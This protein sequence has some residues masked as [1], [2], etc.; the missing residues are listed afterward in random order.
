MEQTSE[1]DIKVIIADRTYKLKVLPQDE[2]R[3]VQAAKVIKHR[4][5]E[6]Q[7]AYGAKDKYD[8]LAM[9]ALLICVEL[10]EKQEHSEQ[11]ILDVSNKLSELDEILTDFM[12][13]E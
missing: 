11:E 8:Y 6:L 2:N 12:T 9:A 4:M 13:K 5:R 10:L 3:V 7:D 1:K